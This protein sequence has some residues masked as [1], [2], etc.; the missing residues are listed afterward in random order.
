MQRVNFY[1]KS[2]ALYWILNILFLNIETTVLLRHADAWA[3]IH[4]EPLPMQPHVSL[5]S[6]QID[7]IKKEILFHF[8]L[9]A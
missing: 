5:Y 9:N 3:L 2:V 1:I 6:F 4:Q 8:N 7:N